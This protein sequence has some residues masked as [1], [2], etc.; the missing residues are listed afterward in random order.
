MEIKERIEKV[1]QIVFEDETLQI[2]EKTCAKDIRN[3]DSIHHITILSMLEETF[4]IHF[5]IDEIMSMECV[6]DMIK[7]VKSK[8]EA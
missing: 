5:E 6:G 7:I 8:I 2:S 1:L 3:W 4:K